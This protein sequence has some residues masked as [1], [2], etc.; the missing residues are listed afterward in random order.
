LISSKISVLPG[1][2][3]KNKKSYMNIT[4]VGI[5]YVGLSNAVLL[6]QQHHVVALDVDAYK[7]DM[8]NKHQSPIEDREIQT[9]LSNRSLNLYATQDKREA[10]AQAD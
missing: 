5:G 9:F 10:Y 6:A 3:F 2:S 1:Y 7:V 8:L 4:V